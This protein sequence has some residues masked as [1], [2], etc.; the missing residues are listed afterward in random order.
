MSQAVHTALQVRSQG[1]SG[2]GPSGGDRQPGDS[3]EKPKALGELTAAQTA[4]LSRQIWQTRSPL[5]RPSSW[6][7]WRLDVAHGADTPRLPEEFLATVV[8]LC[9]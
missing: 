7:L 4:G 9:A 5:A 2:A 6:N 8:L 1:S 3:L